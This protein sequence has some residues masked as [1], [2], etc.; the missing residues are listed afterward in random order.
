MSS[1]CFRRCRRALHCSRCVR[2]F[3]SR[4]RRGAPSDA[5]DVDRRAD[6]DVVGASQNALS[7]VACAS[8]R[9]VS[10]SGTR[11]RR[12]LSGRHRCLGRAGVVRPA[13]PSLGGLGASCPRWR[14][15]VRPLHR[16]S[17]GA[18][19]YSRHHLRSGTPGRQTLELAVVG[20]DRA[21][22]H[23]SRGAECCAVRGVVHLT[24]HLRRQPHLP[25]PPMA[26]PEV[27]LAGG[28]GM[29]ADDYPAHH[30]PSG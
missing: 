18:L 25:F 11:T 24:C 21:D 28:V 12:R 7:G 26:A 22:P 17:C 13:E 10:R 1:R 27:T 15:A 23:S 20:I 4:S 30:E 8:A 9:A 29:A 14:A 2:G 19:H 5:E 3:R 16:P 6:A